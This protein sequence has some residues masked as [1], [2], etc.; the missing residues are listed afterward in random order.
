MV[1]GTGIAGMSAAISASD[2]GAQ[3]LL[4]T[5]RAFGRSNS[6]MAQGGI[7]VPAD[8][9]RD[10]SLMLADMQS[11][12][13]PNLDF[14]RASSFVSELPIVAERLGGWGLQFDVADDGSPMRRLAGGLSS[15]RILTVGDEIGRPL[16][17]ILR[18]EVSTRCQVMVQRPVTDVQIE[19]SEFRL[20]TKRG[21]V[22][23]RSVVIATGGV[24]YQ[25]AIATGGLTSNPPNE[26]AALRISLE[27][28]GIEEVG[29]RLFQWHPFGLAHSVNGV[30]AAC[31]PE[32]VAALGPRLIGG[33]GTKISSLPAPRSE[34]VE[35]MNDWT[36][37]ST[38]SE[39]RLT[40]SELSDSDLE[41]FP[42]VKKQIELYGSD[43]VVV[44][45]LHYELSGLRAGLDQET[46]VPGLYLAGEIVGGTHGRERLM[47]MAVGDSLVHGHRAGVNAARIVRDG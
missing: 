13:G 36:R 34:V 16:M 7:Q 27:R 29:R 35:A 41:R 47:G 43:P 31:V 23:A 40:L 26:N 14:N 22:G 17:R 12:G 19:G 9:E 20:Q 10:I 28:L 24:A 32:S 11:V 30:T 1:V 42:K 33:D 2:A 44:P 5:D 15:P 21:D 45:V 8:S 4:V 46:S 18:D 6:I 25:E 3:T 38:F 37:R 39:I